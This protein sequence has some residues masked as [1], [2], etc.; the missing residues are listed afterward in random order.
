MLIKNP[1]L[2]PINVDALLEA[3]W[4]GIHDV[5]QHGDRDGLDPLG[6]LPLQVVEVGD[7]ATAV[8]GSLQN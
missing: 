7:A 8:D 6:Y 5:L 2:L 3:L 1:S 4:P